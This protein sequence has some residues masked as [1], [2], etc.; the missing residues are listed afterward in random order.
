MGVSNGTPNVI[1]S[2]VEPGG[3]KNVAWPSLL[4][5]S[6]QNPLDISWESDIIHEIFRRN[7]DTARAGLATIRAAGDSAL[8]T[9]LP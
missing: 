2:G 6:I 4:R 3:I 1:I 5:L 7:A 9:F 8:R